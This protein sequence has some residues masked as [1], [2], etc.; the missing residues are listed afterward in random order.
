M[1][2]GAVLAVALG[3]PLAGSANSLAGDYLAARQATYLGDYKAAAEY[4]GKSILFDPSNGDL[5]E[6]AVLASMSVGDFERAVSFANRM[7][8]QGMA[9]Q[10]AYMA[11]MA[12]YG[13]AENYSD[14]LKQISDNKG[15]GPLVDGLAKA[16]A[17]LGQGDMSAALVQFD[18][19]AKSD[20]LGAFAA[21]HKALALA[22]VGDFEG[23]EAIFDSNAMG[24]MQMTR[25]A[26]MAR[27]EILS[28]LNRDAEA[29]T[30]IDDAFGPDID[31]GLGELRAALETGGILPFSHVRSAR[32]G[33]A[34]VF[35]TLAGALSNEQNDD[36]TLMYVRVAEY[37]R[38]D[39]VDALLLTA[40]LLDKMG[41][42]DLAV[43]AFKKVPRDV[44]TYYAA[45]LGRAGALRQDGKVD[46][47]VEVL[48]QLA[49][50]HGNLAVV[51][52]TLG[53]VMRQLERYDEAVQAYT[54]AIGTY[55]MPDQAQW[56]LYYARGIA[57]ERLS[58][59]DASEADF[60]KALEL[61]PEQPQVLNY[62]GYSL[63]EKQEK[64]D[65]A[66]AMIERAVA[67]QPDQ[68][69]IVD[70]LGWALFRM[71]RYDEAV[72]H[73]E[74]AAELMAVDPVVND[75]LGDVYW[76]V[77]RKLEARFQWRR[78]LSFVAFD[79]MT[80]EADPERIRRKLEVGLDQVLSEEGAPSLNVATE[81][82]GN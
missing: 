6:R 27:A 75:H 33:L 47:A 38:P 49:E 4:Y 52:S 65:E 34:E 68:G 37:L 64:L 29:I 41:Q 76:A 51:Q 54:A 71:G 8:E 16:W 25:R 45:E 80:Q 82:D 30:L 73:M 24:A 17:E 72:G 77:G 58:N 18:V 28:Q 7:T 70:S 79:Q 39:H 10:I 46:A 78:A 13:A 42:Y 48:T 67:A 57:N 35:Y 59:W 31:P 69:Y 22:S 23:A 74:H 62:L 21:Y 12:G 15:V 63:V 32:D 53:D 1:L 56:F 20:G 66:L 36:F 40:E 11:Q 61:N 2:K 26:V 5:L 55:D 3:L 9:S 44:P 50:T 43:Q 19:V 14:I 60:R 81:S